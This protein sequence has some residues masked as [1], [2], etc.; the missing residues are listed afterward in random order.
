MNEGGEDGDDNAL[1]PEIS[2]T[3]TGKTNTPLNSLIESLPFKHERT[4]FH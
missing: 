3:N 1:R 2:I 4:R